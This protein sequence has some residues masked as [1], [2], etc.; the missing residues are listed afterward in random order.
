MTILLY[1]TAAAAAYLFCG[2]NPAIVLSRVVYHTDIREKGS[3]IR[4]LRISGVPSAD[5]GRGWSSCAI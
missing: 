1:L 3:A 5:R 2:I 4:G